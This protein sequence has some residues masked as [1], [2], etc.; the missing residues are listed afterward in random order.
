MVLTSVLSACKIKHQFLSI[1][2]PVLYDM[3]SNFISNY[4]SPV[5]L[6]PIRL[7]KAVLRDSASVFLNPS[8]YQCVRSMPEYSGGN[9]HSTVMCHITIFWLTV[10]MTVVP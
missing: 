4:I 1:V 9:R 10:Y 5:E 3:A 6:S 7:P 2:F 8:S